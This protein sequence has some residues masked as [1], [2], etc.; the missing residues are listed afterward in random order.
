[1]RLQAAHH[2]PK[3]THHIIIFA[4]EKDFDDDMMV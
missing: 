2:V 3:G 4:P 1:M